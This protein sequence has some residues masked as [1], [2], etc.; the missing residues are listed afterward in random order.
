MPVTWLKVAVAKIQPKTIGQKLVVLLAVGLGLVF[1]IG[2]VSTVV[3]E[4]ERA[5]ALTTS[6]VRKLT[7]LMAAHAG[8]SERLDKSEPLYTVF[9][10]DA[11][12][13]PHFRL[14]GLS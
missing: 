14:G 10:L 5:N 8:Q 4:T 3:T 9:S 11:H 2:G 12:P 13:D 7:E 1:A 6:A